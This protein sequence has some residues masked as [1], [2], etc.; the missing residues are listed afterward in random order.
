MKKILFL[1]ASVCSTLFAYSQNYAPIETY[2]VDSLDLDEVSDQDKEL[3]DYALKEY[4]KSK[5]DT[6]KVNAIN[7]IVEESYDPSIWSKYNEWIYSF[8]KDKKS[9]DPTIHYFYRFS[10]GIYWNN[11]GLYYSDQGIVDSVKVNYDRAVEIC[12]E[13]DN[14]SGKATL[15]NNLGMWY[16]EQGKLALALDHLLDALQIHQ[17][18]KNDVGVIVTTSNLADLYFT[19]EEYDKTRFYYEWSLRLS[20]EI[21]SDEDIAISC[22]NMGTILSH[23]GQFLE[24]LKH[25]QISLEI[26]KKIGYKGGI[27]TSY[28]NIGAAYEDLDSLDLAMKNF[29]LSLKLAEE[30]GDKND[31]SSTLTRIA[32]LEFEKG[33]L[34]QAEANGLKAYN[35]AVEIE[36]IFR[37]QATTQ[38]L[39]K[40]YEKKGDSKKELLYYKEYILLSDSLSNTSNTKRLMHIR[41]Q[42]EYDQKT[43]KDSMIQADLKKVSDAQIEAGELKIAAQDKQKWY[44]FGVLGLFAIF[45]IFIFNRF[46]AAKKKKLIIEKQKKQVDEAFAELE[47]KNNEI[48]DSITYAKRIQ[49]AILPPRELVSSY[50]KNSFILYKPKDIVAGDFYWMEPIEDTVLF[51]AADCTGHGVP[52]AMVSVICNNGLNRSVREHKLLDPGKILDKT[53]EIV[54]SEFEKSEDEVKDGMDIALCSLNGSI[55][56]YAGA[57]NPLWIIRNGASEIEEIK[58]D[59]QPIG[60]FLEAKPYVTHE[61]ELNEGDAFYIFSDGYA[62]QFGGERNKKFKSV[63]FKKLLISIQDK[64]MEEQ[65]AKID[66]VFEEWKKDIE[67]LDDVCVIGVKI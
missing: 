48:M 33:N 41:F 4:S 40:L 27:A 23:E 66:Q 51:A 31:I 63:N 67:Q 7:L 20:R 8:L 37:I 57:H 16:E 56:K 64:S 39:H 47:E 5:H 38:L 55:L 45:S 65:K 21:E 18:A 15:L 3:I 10:I 30:L 50:L 34:S 1:L 28:H 22:N 26:N 14:K 17:E 36:S 44:L 59:K 62:D 60:T 12:E 53:R 2:L 54:I 46:K 13:L 35:Y 43:L 52:G 29:H 58:A 61:I 9:E 49:S 42:S 24:A 11:R 6:D 32:W 25:Y 19:Q